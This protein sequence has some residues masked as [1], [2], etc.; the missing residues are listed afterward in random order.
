MPLVR[1][2]KAFWNDLPLLTKFL[3]LIGTPACL[4]AYGLAL[5]FVGESEERKLRDQLKYTHTQREVLAAL[6]SDLATMESAARGYLVVPLPDLLTRFEEAARQ[7][8]DDAATVQR[9]AGGS[10][11]EAVERLQQLVIEKIAASRRLLQAAAMEP[12]QVKSAFLYSERT[13][14]AVKDNVAALESNARAMEEAG[15]RRLDS[16][17]RY[18]GIAGG[19][20]IGVGTLGAMV[21]AV[22]FVRSLR[23]RMLRL[24]QQARALK[25]ESPI[26]D[27]Q[28][29]A[30]EI[31]QLQ[32][33][34]QRSSEVLASRVS[35][36]RAQ[37]MQLRTFMDQSGAIVYLKDL[38]S[39]FLMVNRGYERAFGLAAKD[40][41][42]RKPEELFGEKLGRRL[43]ENDLAV[44]ESREPAEFEEK[45][46]IGGKEISYVSVKAPLLDEEG[47]PYGI[48]GISI[49]PPVVT[50]PEPRE[51]AGVAW[52]EAA[53]TKAA[54]L[55][56]TLPQLAETV[57]SDL[58]RVLANITRHSR[59][60]IDH[61][62][63]NDRE[64]SPA[65]EILQ[66]S[67]RAAALAMQLR[68]MMPTPPV[69]Q[70]D[71]ALRGGTETLLLAEDEP[72]VAQFEAR[73]LR[74]LGY[75]VL[76]AADG[77][78]AERILSEPAPVDLLITDLKMPGLS[79]YDLISV[80]RLR[81]PDL[82]ILVVT[83]DHTSE[84]GDLAVE[85]LPKPFEIGAMADKV[86][87]M[88]DSSLMPA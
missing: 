82:K 12:A 86:R 62:P 3:A 55:P 71:P 11:P 85:I 26:I 14:Q 53:T 6:R 56:E 54:V 35:D 40:A 63:A 2:F 24:Q 58:D 44:I 70:R 68:A 20:I 16:S 84:L 79:G 41:L 47:M 23:R 66:A 32:A 29:S 34:I 42:G 61:V 48:C 22:V 4:L 73:L 9:R 30:D 52:E 13:M 38:E 7:A 78:E 8:G 51:E 33:E 45:I 60:F 18:K 67:E 50:A 1:Q 15:G 37:E 87:Q 19:G 65:R 72:L 74:S 49:R 31:G 43:R 88:L 46:V 17:V 64:I 76:C 25:M 57:S 77:R 10:S 21:S 36:L 69:E 39:R 5:V 75:H 80:A 81:Y 59:Q 83:G 27:G 28:T